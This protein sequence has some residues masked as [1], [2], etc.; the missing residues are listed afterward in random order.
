MGDND[1]I[2]SPLHMCKCVTLATWVLLGWAILHQKKFMVVFTN[3]NLRLVNL[4]CNRFKE[5][6]MP[7]PYN[8][9][10]T[11]NLSQ[12]DHVDGSVT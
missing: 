10:T 2:R 5:S 4:C 7:A 11:H 1:S 12:M 6:L 9:V 8:A 3:V